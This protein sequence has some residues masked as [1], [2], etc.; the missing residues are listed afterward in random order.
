MI[1]GNER[2]IWLP[3]KQRADYDQHF[4]KNDKKQ[5]MPSEK[6]PVLSL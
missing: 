5:E 4:R 1:T 6:F 2:M 3:K